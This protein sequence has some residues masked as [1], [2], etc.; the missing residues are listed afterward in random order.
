MTHRRDRANPPTEEQ[1]AEALHEAIERQRTGQHPTPLVDPDDAD[2][3]I[4]A[5]ML[6]GATPPEPSP[7]FLA[8]LA[9]Q[10][11]AL[12]D[13]P[14]DDAAPPVTPIAPPSRRRVV[15]RRALLAGTLGTAAGLAAGAALATLAEHQAAESPGADLIGRGGAWLAV[16]TIDQLAPGGVL[17]FTTANI[18]GHLI[19]KTDGSFLAL[20]AA[21]THLGCLVNWNATDRSFDCPCH[22]WR[23]S[24]TGAPYSASSHYQPLPQLQVRVEG[25]EVQVYVPAPPATPAGTY[26][27]G[28]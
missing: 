22:D 9:A 24:S 28:T 21:C 11:E 15:S 27:P 8:T 5:G 3:I 4:T 18:A 6:H 10:L 26:T 25:D 20:S 16:A 13:D 12:Q 7:E 17:R 1:R 23:Y 19:R 2:A 14:A